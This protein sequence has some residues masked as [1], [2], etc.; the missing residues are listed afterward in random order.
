MHVSFFN[1]FLI[2]TVNFK[3]VVMKVRMIDHFHCQIMK[4]VVMVDFELAVK[5]LVL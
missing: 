4:L 5:M 1:L 2:F 3:L